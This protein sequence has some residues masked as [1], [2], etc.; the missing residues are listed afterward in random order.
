MKLADFG[1]AQVF[2]GE[3]SLKGN[4]NSVMLGSIPWMAPE[5]IKHFS[6]HIGRKSDIWSF[7]CTV[8]EMATAAPPWANVG[9]PYAIMYKVAQN[10]ESPPIPEGFDETGVDFLKHCFQRNTK[11]RWSSQHLL[12]HS[13]VQKDD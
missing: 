7:G 2:Q 6:D 4:S 12:E 1:C 9:N 5:A 13:F 10:E 8:I 3:D 11:A